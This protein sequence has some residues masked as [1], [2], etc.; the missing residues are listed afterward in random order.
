MDLATIIGLIGAVIVVVTVMIWMAVH[1]Q[2]FLPT[3]RP[4]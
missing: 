1:R 2:N 4:S 3:P